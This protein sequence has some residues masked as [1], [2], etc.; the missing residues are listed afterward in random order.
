MIDHRACEKS[1]EAL[2]SRVAT[3][4]QSASN[5][6]RAIKRFKKLIWRLRRYDERRVMLEALVEKAGCGKD[7]DQC[8]RTCDGALYR[9]HSEAREMKSRK[10][11]DIHGQENA[12]EEDEQGK[13]VLS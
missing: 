9:L 4:K 10:R 1:I 6:E 8:I 3:Y 2:K 12:R 7:V 13:A 5:Y 11:G